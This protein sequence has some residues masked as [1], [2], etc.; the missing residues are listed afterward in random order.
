SPPAPNVPRPS[1]MPTK[2]NV[3]PG[4]PPV[5]GICWPVVTSGRRL[6]VGCNGRAY[7]GADA[8]GSNAR[9]GLDPTTDAIV[10]SSPTILAVAVR[11]IATSPE[12]VM[13]EL[14]FGSSPLGPRKDPRCA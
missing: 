4:A 8:Y 2:R 6:T 11:F 13:R 7:G 5:S 10:V 9:A 12:D 1:G 3:V 14:F